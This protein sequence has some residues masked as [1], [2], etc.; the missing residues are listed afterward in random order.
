MF[1]DDFKKMDIAL[2]DIDDNTAHE[3]T[4]I[5]LVWIITPQ[6]EFVFQYE[7]NIELSPARKLLLDYFGRAINFHEMTVGIMWVLATS[8][9]ISAR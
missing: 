3:L 4:Q 6:G 5:L 9:K 1:I 8:E 2:V 7:V